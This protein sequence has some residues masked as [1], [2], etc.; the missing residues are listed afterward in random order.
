MPAAQLE[1]DAHSMDR[2][3]FDGSVGHLQL[4]AALM[5]AGDWE[6]ALLM[7][8]WMQVRMLCN[9]FGCVLNYVITWHVTLGP[10]G[11]SSAAGG[12]DEGR[13][14]GAYAAEARLNAG[15]RVL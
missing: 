3:L 13:R 4:L 5:K 7:L 2:P 15:K 8:D 10:R 9:T 14:L 12:A 6:H 11:S 1:L